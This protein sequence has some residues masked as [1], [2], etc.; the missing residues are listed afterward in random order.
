MKKCNTI[1]TS[2][3]KARFITSNMNIECKGFNDD[4]VLMFEC[5]IDKTV[6]TVVNVEIFDNT[7]F[8]MDVT[9]TSFSDHFDAIMFFCE[10]Y[11]CLKKRSDNDDYNGRATTAIIENKLTFKATISSEDLDVSTFADMFDEHLFKECKV[12][13]RAQLDRTIWLEECEAQIEKI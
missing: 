2:E 7:G 12:L 13:S 4:G 11:H 6:Y 5:D 3:D 8:F 10:Q 1:K 9:R